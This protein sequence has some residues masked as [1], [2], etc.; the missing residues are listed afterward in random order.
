MPMSEMVS[1]ATIV[2]LVGL[3]ALLAA[4]E[5]ALKNSHRSRLRQLEA[6]DVAF[7]G[8]ARRL[9]EN[10]SRLILSMRTGRGLLRLLTVGLALND[11][12]S[13]ASQAGP[14]SPLGVVSVLVIVWFSVSILVFFAESLVLRGPELWGARLAVLVSTS[15]TLVSPIVWV[16]MGLANRVVGPFGDRRYQLVT[17]EQIMTLVDAGQEGGAIEKEEKDMIFSIFQLDDTLAREVM[18]PRIDILAFEDTISLEEATDTLLK[19]GLSRAPVYTDSIDNVIGLVYV[20]DLL[21]AWRQGE[22]DTPISEILRDPYFVPE[23]KKADELLTEMQARRVQMAIVVDEYGG[24]AGLVTFE[25]IVE[26]IVGEV[27]DE[28]DIGE[29]MPYLKV[30]EREFIFRGGI[31]LDD[32]NAITD[33]DLPKETSETLGGFIYGELGRVPV[34][35]DVVEAGGMR[36]VVEQVIG[37]R[38]RN[39]RAQILAPAPEGPEE[40]NRG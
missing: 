7:V 23:A 21:R 38:I 26:E 28:Y 31:D 19:T 30:N 3:N 9:M 20:K 12:V 33:A 6:E 24:T 29:E 8:L 1:L 10:S 39:V 17:E 37:R 36:L 40:N 35:G 11:Y 14:V 2:L 4:G 27:Q 34:P 22:L 16:M 32:V 18:V 15:I 13:R 5:S 25:D